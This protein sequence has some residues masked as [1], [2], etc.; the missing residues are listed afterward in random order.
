[1]HGVVVIPTYNER[2][3]LAS[4]VRQLLTSQADLDVLVVDDNS[5]DGTGAIA[6]GLAAEEPRVAVLHRTSKDGLGSAY[7][8]GFR[9]AL[10]GPYEFV[11]QM[12]A[13]FSH[14]VEDLEG[15]IAAVQDAGADVAIGSRN[16]TG[17]HAVSR[18]PL[19][20]LISA[21]GS[22]YARGLLG[23]PIRDCTGGFK[24]FRRQA[25]QRIDL[26]RVRARGYA[27]QVEMNHRCHQAGLRLVEVPIVFPDR[28]A[29]RSKMTWRIFVEG[30]LAVIRLRL[31][32]R[33]TRL[34]GTPPG[35]DLPRM[36]GA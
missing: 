5:P 23:L 4:L 27:F 25:L 17:G 18:S 26:D 9:Q 1:M 11:V 14:R 12:D 24:C 15:L 28:V 8:A 29:G 30:W 2:E 22:I 3:N 13:D 19:R 33:S 35:P 16:V 10:T 32:S 31:E 34:G 6:D 36:T 21:G 7:L 20:R